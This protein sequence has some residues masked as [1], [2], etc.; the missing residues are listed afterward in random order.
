[1]TSLAGYPSLA[2]P[3][4]ATG[5][6][7]TLTIVSKSKKVPVR[8]VITRPV[9]SFALE[10]T[11]T[12]SVGCICSLLASWKS[13]GPNCARLHVSQLPNVPV[14]ILE[15]VTVHEAVILRFLVCRSPVGDRL[16]NQ[17]V[18]FVPAPR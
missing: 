3:S 6:F 16:A 12:S 5:R 11:A 15:S 1:M 10:L 2:V 13:L 8:I 14:R 4:T 9:H 18:D 7:S 17:F